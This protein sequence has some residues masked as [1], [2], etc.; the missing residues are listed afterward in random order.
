MVEWGIDGHAPFLA[1]THL[2]TFRIAGEGQRAEGSLYLCG[3]RFDVSRE[4]PCRLSSAYQYTFNDDGAT[5]IA[6]TFHLHPNR[7]QLV[8]SNIVERVEMGGI[9][10]NI[11][12]L[13]AIDLFVL[14]P[15]FFLIDR[16]EFQLLDHIEHQDC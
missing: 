2:F 5:G 1:S 12:G 13:G 7:T 10:V 14:R 9:Q 8:V 6:L 11:D 16:I 3:Q 4:P 15:T